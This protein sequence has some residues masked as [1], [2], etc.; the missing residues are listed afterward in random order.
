[1]HTHFINSS[2]VVRCFAL[3]NTFFWF[4]HV[5]LFFSICFSYYTFIWSQFL[6]RETQE[7]I[8]GLVSVLCF[9]TLVM[10]LTFSS[11]W[12]T[13]ASPVPWYSSEYRKQLLDFIIHYELIQRTS[14]S[15]ASKPLPFLFGGGTVAA[16]PTGSRT[17]ALL[18]V[19]LFASLSPCNPWGQHCGQRFAVAPQK[20][21]DGQ[22][23]D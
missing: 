10:C 22:E 3:W 2:W 13:Y 8:W 21:K 19:C 9:E 6:I 15:S 11:A 20:S 17:A 23:A 4:P 1:M 7:L 18:P 14:F 5:L 12:T 16:V